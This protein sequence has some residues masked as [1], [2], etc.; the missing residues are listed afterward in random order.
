MEAKHQQKQV[1]KKSNRPG[2]FKPGRGGKRDPRINTKGRP[3][4]SI[5]FNDRLKRFAAMKPARLRR[6]IQACNAAIRDG[7][8][9]P[10]E[11]ETGLDLAAVNCLMA[12]W[13]A[14]KWPY[15]TYAIE[16]MEPSKDQ[17][18]VDQTVRVVYEEPPEWAK[19]QTERSA[20][21]SDR[22]KPKSP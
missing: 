5:S 18:E 14:K 20:S 10:R 11:I 4:G 17:L 9:F 8:P 13:T 3:K 1:E 21:G 15:A 19:L 6:L 2:T 7:V 22:T 16:R 12:T